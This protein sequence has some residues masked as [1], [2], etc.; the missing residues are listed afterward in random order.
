MERKRS[1][2]TNNQLCVRKNIRSSLNNN[3]Y[4]L[5]AKLLSKKTKN[6]MSYSFN[7]IKKYSQYKEKILKRMASIYTKF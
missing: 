7:S 6:I 2:G 4:S 5:L 3:K 1:I